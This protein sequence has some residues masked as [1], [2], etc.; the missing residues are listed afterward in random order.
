MSKRVIVSTRHN[1]R[2]IGIKTVS[3]NTNTQQFYCSV[4]FVRDNPGEPVPEETFTHSTLIVVINQE[5][6]EIKR[7]AVVL[8]P[9][10]GGERQVSIKGVGRHQKFCQS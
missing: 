8:A 1:S 7:A 4:D 2:L 10:F 3:N 6:R 9:L 5:S